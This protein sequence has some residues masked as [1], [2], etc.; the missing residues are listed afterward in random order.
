[1]TLPLPLEFF[2]LD[3]TD[4][5]LDNSV[6][7]ERGC[8]LYCR[9]FNSPGPFSSKHPSPLLHPQPSPGLDKCPLGCKII[10]TPNP[11]MRATTLDPTAHLQEI[12][13][14][15][16]AINKIP[17]LRKSANDLVFLYNSCK[18]ERKRY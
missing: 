12:Q 6:L 3:I 16:S 5:E 11:A 15:G 2:N 9:V 14:T 8:L 1:M 17:A 7:G 18:K 10:T 13:R 4:T